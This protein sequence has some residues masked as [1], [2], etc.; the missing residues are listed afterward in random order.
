M[1]IRIHLYSDELE[2][3]NPLGN[4]RNN[5]LSAFYF[6]VGNLETKYWSSLTNIH[7]ALLCNYDIV[8]RFGYDDVLKPLLDDIK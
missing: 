6:L 1:F 5:K 7:L 8:K 2:L 3:C 4:K